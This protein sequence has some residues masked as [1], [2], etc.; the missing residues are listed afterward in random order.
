[1]LMLVVNKHCTSQGAEETILRPSR[2]T[3]FKVFWAFNLLYIHSKSICTWTGNHSLSL[4]PQAKPSVSSASE[5]D[6]LLPYRKCCS[7][8]KHRLLL[9]ALSLS[10]RL[11]VVASTARKTKVYWSATNSLLVRSNDYT[12]LPAY[13]KE[14]PSKF[15]VLLRATREPLK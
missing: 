14:R 5:R 3:C 4:L 2:M 15:S 9:E 11:N 12:P 1:M 13:R 8:K 6:Y 7:W 10:D